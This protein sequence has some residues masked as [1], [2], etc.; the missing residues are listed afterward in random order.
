MF[1]IGLASIIEADTDIV[2]VVD[3]STLAPEFALV[4][5]RQPLELSTPLQSQFAIDIGTHKPP[6]RR[7]PVQA[8]GTTPALTLRVE[9]MRG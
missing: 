1:I 9:M 4:A 5:K 6:R 7:T 2:I 8:L 3:R